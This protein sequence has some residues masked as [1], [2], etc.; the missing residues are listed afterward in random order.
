[1]VTIIRRPKGSANPGGLYD[2]SGG[3]QAQ[4][5]SRGGGGGSSSGGSGPSNQ[6]DLTSQQRKIAQR[7]LG[8]GVVRITTNPRTGEVSYIGASGRKVTFPSKDKLTYSGADRPGGIAT[9]ES[10]TADNI[11]ARD[12]V[13]KEGIQ[14]KSIKETSAQTAL[15]LEFTEQNLRSDFIKDSDAYKALRTRY[16]EEARARVTRPTK[17]SVIFAGGR[18]KASGLITPV[19]TKTINS[20]E[21]TP[22]FTLDPETSAEVKARQ[23]YKNIQQTEPTFQL[24]E[25]DIKTRED[26]ATIEKGKAFFGRQLNTN[27]AVLMKDIDLQME[28]T[29][30]VIEKIKLNIGRIT[31]KGLGQE[32]DAPYSFNIGSSALIYVGT[33]ATTA[34]DLSPI[35]M[36]NKLFTQ[37]PL[38]TL[39]AY[40]VGGAVNVVTAIKEDRLLKSTTPGG[41]TAELL[42]IGT[43]VYLGGK[44]TGLT[45]K[46]ITGKVKGFN[47]KIAEKIQFKKEQAL[48]DK[49]VLKDINKGEVIATKNK[50]LFRKEF[51]QTGQLDR[52]TEQTT[53]T[54]RTESGRE[55]SDFGDKL[56][57]TKRGGPVTKSLIKEGSYTDPAT[58]QVYRYGETIGEITFKRGSYD[59]LKDPLKAP[60]IEA[61][62]VKEA[63]P[64]SKSP[65]K[66]TT[67]KDKFTRE[68]EIYVRDTY[69]DPATGQVYP[70]SRPLGK[71]EVTGQTVPA[72]KVASEFKFSGDPFKDTRLSF[73]ER[74]GKLVDKAPIFGSTSGAESISL[75][76]D[77]NLNPVISE[78]KAIGG[79][80]A[81]A[82]SQGP[83]LILPPQIDTT[84]PRKTK[85]GI[86]G[87]IVGPGED[88]DRKG[89]Y[90]PFIEIDIKKDTRANRKP[91]TN[92]KTDL[93]T[94]IDTGRDIKTEQEKESDKDRKIITSPIIDTIPDLRQDTRQRQDTTRPTK[95]KQPPPKVILMPGKSA[96]KKKK[97]ARGEDSYNVYAKQGGRF[98]KVNKKPLPKNRALNLGGKA[99]DNTASATFKVSRTGKKTTERDSTGFNLMG[100]FRKKGKNYIEKNKYRIDT[101]GELQGITVKGWLARRKAGGFF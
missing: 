76:K 40:T 59:P 99:V 48:L 25:L 73:S 29:G 14:A 55:I 42:G 56:P 95:P 101:P 50:G 84:I 31:A 81:G 5:K 69:T 100:K 10:I 51:R 22:A 94:A 26:Y 96:K 74:I 97:K 88:K 2:S 67:L 91:I 12:K 64:A 4:R 46:G 32:L 83:T 13:Q 58:G 34:L 16:K 8:Q 87:G 72:S 89:I 98:I 45:L 85:A 78:F 68:T 24:A 3:A 15:A 93:G 37:G 77:L 36:G 92:F 28:E 49:K 21:N 53:F 90:S 20:N 52:T 86:F 7:Q 43:G 18:V 17:T 65:G 19:V 54:R 47:K 79:E 60:K 27:E 70:F 35:G 38:K 11:K 33:T 23:A 41:R 6:K 80:I 62:I 1:M 61:P 39:E 9:R 44:V 63:L 71:F 75:F 57:K 82:F 66:V 30:N